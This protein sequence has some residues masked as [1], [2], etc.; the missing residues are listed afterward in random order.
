[1]EGRERHATVLGEVDGL[2]VERRIGVHVAPLV[3]HE[4]GEPARHRT[5]ESPRPGLLRAV[6][7]TLVGTYVVNAEAAP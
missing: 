6:V 3:L 7:K 1:M 4:V 5:G 2:A